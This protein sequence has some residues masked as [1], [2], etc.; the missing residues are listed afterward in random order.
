MF[1]NLDLFKTAI[2]MARHSGL[3]QAITSQ[4]VA[5]ADTPGYRAKSVTPF[6]D[7]VPRTT[8][9]FTLRTTRPSHVGPYTQFGHVTAEART[10]SDP[11]GNSVNLETEILNSV[12]AK[13][14]HDRALAI[15]R[16]SLGILR[17]ALSKQ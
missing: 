15:Y 16:A 12:D 6:E 9:A 3:K 1:Q 2:S 5:N 17:S 14:G 11:N 4:N 10:Q 13:R 7:L 8:D